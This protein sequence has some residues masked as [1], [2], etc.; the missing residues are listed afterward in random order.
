LGLGSGNS[1]YG[2]FQLYPRLKAVTVA[3]VPDDIPLWSAV[4]LPLSISTAAA[5]LYLKANLGLKFPGKG[6]RVDEPRLTHPH[7]KPSPT[8]TKTAACSSSGADPHR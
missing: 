4:V 2:G 1:Q 8:R 5:G 7:Q 3:K 6:E